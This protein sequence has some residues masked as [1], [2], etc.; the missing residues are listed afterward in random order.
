MK[1]LKILFFVILFLPLIAFS[2]V[3]FGNL[4]AHTSYSDGEGDPVQAFNHARYIAGLDIQAITDHAHYFVQPLED[5]SDKFAR[6]KEYAAEFTEPGVF[7]ALAGFEW[8]ATGYG[9]INVYDTEEWIS[10]DQVDLF[11]LYEWIVKHKALA[12]FNHPVRDFGDNFREFIYFPEVDRYINLLEVGNG[13]W[14]SGEVISQEMEMAYRDALRKGWHVGATA[15]QDNHKA[16]WGSAND[17]RTAVIAD[18]LDYESVMRAL[19]SRHV[20]ATEDKN[21][22]VMFS[23]DDAIMGDI[24]Y[25]ATKVTLRISFEDIGDPVSSATLVSL[26]GEISLPVSGE[27]WDFST[28]ITLDLNYEWVYLKIH[29]KDGDDIITSPIWFQS[30]SGFYVMNPAFSP[31]RPA[32]EEPFILKFDLVNWNEETSYVDLS[33][34]LSNEEV[35]NR[36]VRLEPLSRASTSIELS[37]EEEGLLQIYI[38]GELSWEKPLHLARFS[39]LLDTTHENGQEFLNGELLKLIEDLSGRVEVLRGR[40]RPA[41]LKGKS[42]FILPLPDAGGFVPMLKKLSAKEMMFI[43]DHLNEGGYLVL[44]ASRDPLEPEIVATYNSLLETLGL[45]VRFSADGTAILEDGVERDLVVY[46]VGRGKLL[47]ISHEVALHPT[48][49]F[50]EQ[51]M[52]LLGV[53]HPGGEK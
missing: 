17:A 4:H 48:A 33:I 45:K 2:A 43:S 18:S 39:A 13:N 49:E 31:S 47:L 7:L 50:E 14:A 8:T 29:E 51:F 32:H 1:R 27:K 22:Y 10:R 34:R 12:Q 36:R 40:M 20:Y 24:V 46:N 28:D 44:V 23:A 26:D 15:N 11:Q 30:S 9:H 19:R 3:Y 5:G 16:N 52:K 42:I 37:S 35:F 21:A 6:T 53:E 38:N 41:S 25:D